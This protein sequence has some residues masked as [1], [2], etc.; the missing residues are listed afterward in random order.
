MTDHRLA[1]VLVVALLVLA[2]FGGLWL[3]GGSAVAPPSLD[4][5]ASAFEVSA[6]ES[7]PLAEDLVEP[8]A[9]DT[10]RDTGSSP[11]EVGESVAGGDEQAPL[12][13]IQG[14]LVDENDH[15]IEGVELD[16]M[17]GITV[18]AGATTDALGRFAFTAVERGSYSVSARR[19]AS[20]NQ[21]SSEF[22]PA[23]AVDLNRLARLRI[24]DAMEYALTIRLTRPATLLVRVLNAEGAPALSTHLFVEGAR[25]SVL[26]SFTLQATSEAK[27]DRMR[28]G[29]YSVRLD[30][31]GPD[32]LSR[33]VQLGAGE[34]QEVEIRVDD[35]TGA[36]LVGR[37]VGTDLEALAGHSMRLLNEDGTPRKGVA[38]VVTNSD[39]LF[40]I[41]RL[42]PGRYVLEVDGRGTGAAPQLVQAPVLLDVGGDDVDLGDVLVTY[43]DGWAIAGTLV[44]DQEWAARN[45]AETMHLSVAIKVV[46]AEEGPAN[47]IP[48]LSAISQT[49][50]QHAYLSDVDRNSILWSVGLDHIPTDGVGP[51]GRARLV[52]T[53]AEAFSLTS[54]SAFTP[55]KWHK[56]VDVTIER[57]RC[58]TVDLTFP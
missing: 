23:D 2:G 37:L 9:A 12:A 33:T 24:T 52:I 35:S 39:G 25:S 5:S 22:V 6:T 28:P 8:R 41:G 49:T 14:V 50:V 1:A 11:P 45:L 3:L 58:T 19:G 43:G 30:L 57:G 20:R 47:R 38:S 34:T 15:G 46:D 42:T 55:S 29:E 32:P 18:V 36:L 53:F 16:L 54:S 21:I 13:S 27:F 31:E 48:R 26:R 4:P 10:R 7:G 40:T 44:I 51:S 56:T 17:N